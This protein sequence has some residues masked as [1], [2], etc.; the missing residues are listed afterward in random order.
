MICR[1]CKQPMACSLVYR[2]QALQSVVHRVCGDFALWVCNV[3]I[4]HV[5]L[6]G[7]L[8]LSWLALVQI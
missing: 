6:S 2:P 3:G 4:V 5:W 7:S 8:Q 1:R